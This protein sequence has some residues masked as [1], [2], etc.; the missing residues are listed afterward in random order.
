MKV[1]DKLIQIEYKNKDWDLLKV[2]TEVH[3]QHKFAKSLSTVASSGFLC[4]EP[5]YDGSVAN[6]GDGLKIE[7]NGH[8]LELDYSTAHNL[9][10]LLLEAGLMDFKVKDFLAED[11]YEKK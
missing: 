5:L 3:G 11:V 7:V 2:E 6:T 1:G 9:L 8:Y 10:L 4:K